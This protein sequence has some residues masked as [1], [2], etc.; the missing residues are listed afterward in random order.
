M[1][2]KIEIQAMV[3]WSM[4]HSSPMIMSGSCSLQLPDKIRLVGASPNLKCSANHI[5]NGALPILQ[6]RRRSMP[7]ANLSWPNCSVPNRSGGA[8]LKLRAAR[9]A[10]NYR[11]WLLSGWSYPCQFPGVHLRQR[12]LSMDGYAWGCGVA[13]CNVGLKAKMSSN[14]SH[15]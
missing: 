3:L 11:V 6:L 12:G 4:L 5:S 13:K 10:L 7:S 1:L 14:L 2:T 15:G 8:K 9:A